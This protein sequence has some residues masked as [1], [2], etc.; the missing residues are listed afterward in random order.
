MFEVG[1][2]QVRATS[3][4]PRVPE[5]P[6]GASGVVKGMYAGE[7]FEYEPFTPAETCA[8]RNTYEVPLVR[9]VTVREVALDAVWANVVQVDPLL[10]E[11]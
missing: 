4:L 1:A 6:V 11:Y 9:P 8:T 5:R 2:F 10:L 7:E 3:V